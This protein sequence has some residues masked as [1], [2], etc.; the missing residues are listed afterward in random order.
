ME[1][2]NSLDNVAGMSY[3]EVAGIIQEWII[4]RNAERDREILRY[5]LLDG[6]TYEE[7]STRYMLAHPDEPISS[8]TVKRTIYRRKPQIFAHFPG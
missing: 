7:I 4:G 8:D 1:H 6:L 3:T 5:W 2:K